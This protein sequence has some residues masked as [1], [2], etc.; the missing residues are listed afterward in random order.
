MREDN[1]IIIYI[2]SCILP[3]KFN[4]WTLPRQTNYGFKVVADGSDVG[5]TGITIENNA[6]IISLSSSIADATSVKL[7]YG[8]VGV[9]RGNICDSDDWATWLK[10]LSDA[11]DT[12]YDGNRVIGQSPTAEDGGSLV[13]QNY[14]MNNFLSI[15]YKEFV[16]E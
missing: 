1:R 9:G 5:I 11:N 15:F 13:G 8:G 2:S 10:Y 14:P 4:T 7:T 16:S 3:L 6:I 12:G